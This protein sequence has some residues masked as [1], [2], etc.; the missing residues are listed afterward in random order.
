MGLGSLLAT[1]SDSLAQPLLNPFA[2]PLLMVLE[3]SG[4]V[5]SPVCSNER[6]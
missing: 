3:P 5:A 2:N 4:E 6:S 1:D